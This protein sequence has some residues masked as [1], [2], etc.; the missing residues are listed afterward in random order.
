[1]ATALLWGHA[2]WRLTGNDGRPCLFLVRDKRP[3]VFGSAPV[4]GGSFPVVCCLPLVLGRVADAGR[5][6]PFVH[7]GGSLM[8]VRGVVE[9]FRA[10]GKH[11]EG[12]SV[13]IGRIP[14]GNGQPFADRDAPAPDGIPGSVSLFE[15]LQSRADCVQARADL[16]GTVRHVL[17]SGLGVHASSM[18]EPP[19]IPAPESD[20]CCR[21]LPDG[22]GRPRLVLITDISRGLRRVRGAPL[23]PSGDLN[24]CWNQ[25]W[26]STGGGGRLRCRRAGTGV[27][28]WRR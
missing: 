3:G 23:P 18:P 2:L 25:R 4:R 11:V 27:A 19:R 6:C 5:C 7:A 13:R 24:P 8:R 20:H 17:G 15:H 22:Q 1:M 9:R 26:L 21:C 10:R 12:G 14:L 28:V 16:A